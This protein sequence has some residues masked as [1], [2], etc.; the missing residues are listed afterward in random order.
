ME[1]IKQDIQDATS[2]YLV[3]THTPDTN[4]LDTSDDTIEYIKSF[5]HPHHPYLEPPTTPI[6]AFSSLDAQEHLTTDI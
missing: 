5:L 3:N 2:D 1:D 6:S 4:I